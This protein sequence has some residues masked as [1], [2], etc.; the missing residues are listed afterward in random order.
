MFEQALKEVIK[1]YPC[2]FGETPDRL[3]GTL[4]TAFQKWIVVRLARLE[5]ENAEYRKK[6][7]E[8]DK[9]LEQFSS[10]ALRECAK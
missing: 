5:R 9:A 6:A 2:P 1:A 10:P 7:K 4:T 3:D 8:L